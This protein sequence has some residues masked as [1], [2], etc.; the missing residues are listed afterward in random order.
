MKKFFIL[1][2]AAIVALASCAK[3]EVVYKDAPEEIAFKQITGVMTKATALTEGSLG[4]FAHQ[5]T[6]AYFGNTPFNWDGAYYASTKTWPLEGLLDFTVYYP[7]IATADYAPTTKTLTLPITDAVLATNSLDKIY[8][9]SER[10]TGKK[11]GDNLVAVL[12]HVC[13]KLVVNFDGGDL[14]EFISAKFTGVYLA[15]MVSVNYNNPI[16]VTATGTTE[17]PLKTEDY[18][19]TES[20]GTVGYVLPGNQTSIIITFKQKT[21]SATPI[22][23]TATL[24]PSSTW[25]AHKR[26]T[27]DIKVGANEVIKFSAQT[28]DWVPA[29]PQ[30]GD[31]EL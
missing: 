16:T 18:L 28:E 25:D 15:G 19:L 10:I 29:D 13:A 24:T 14:Y 20:D 17:A 11:K 6:A 1:A 3:T 8:Y 27:Y 23:R 2:S 31:I 4:V 22:V 5:E 21:G 12:H 26:Y 30:P 7:Y 9:G